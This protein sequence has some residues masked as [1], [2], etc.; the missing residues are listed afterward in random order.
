MKTIIPVT[1]AVAAALFL[2]PLVSAHG[3]DELAITSVEGTLLGTAHLED[4]EL[5]FT[6]ASEGTTL[7]GELPAI[8]KAI[9]EVNGR[10]KPKVLVKLLNNER[11]NFRIEYGT[12]LAGGVAT[13]A[14]AG[15]TELRLGGFPDPTLKVTVTSAAIERLQKGQDASSISEAMKNKEILLEGVGAG[16]KFKLWMVKVGA[17]VAGWFSG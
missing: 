1:F 14:S 8:A 7:D 13:D 2:I 15:I 12:T 6:P 5:E 3:A 16:N 10:E 11:L 9:L 17:T 4:G